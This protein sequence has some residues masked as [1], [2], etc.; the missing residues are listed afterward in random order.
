MKKQVCNSNSGFIGYSGYGYGYQIW[1]APDDGFAFVG[2]GDQFAICDPTTDFIFIINSDNQGNGS[3]RPILYHELYK[4]IIH[5][6]GKPLAED[7]AAYNELCDFV[8]NQKLFAFDKGVDTDFAG[9]INNKVYELEENK[10]GIEYIKLC[11]EGEKGELH[12]KNKQGEKTLVF[13]MGYNEFSK[14]PEEG[15]SD[16]VATEF[17]KGNYYDCACS[18]GWAEM[19]KLRIKVQIIDK[20]FGNGCFV[21]SFKD[22]RVTVLMTKTAENFMNEYSGV[23]MGRLKE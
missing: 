10:M 16:M 2:M 21:F 9:V 17:A 15:Y 13:G 12:Y 4:E 7:K 14:F 18:A 8:S 23:A 1:K 20:Y 19:K 3:T 22:D 5:K 6:F 11:F